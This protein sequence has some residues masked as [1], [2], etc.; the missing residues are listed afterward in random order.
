MLR[1]SALLGRLV[2]DSQIGIWPAAQFVPLRPLHRAIELSLPQR[3]RRY[4]L[5]L[6]VLMFVTCFSYA[7]IAFKS[8][9]IMWRLNRVKGASVIANAM[10][11]DFMYIFYGELNRAKESMCQ[12]YKRR[13][14]VKKSKRTSPTRRYA[15]A[16]GIGRPAFGP[17]AITGSRVPM[18]GSQTLYRFTL[19]IGATLP[20][21]LF[22]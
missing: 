6:L 17:D 9:K 3:Y 19:L 1:C 13:H 8:K 18:L 10:D 2:P 7:P 21:C 16:R 11:S 20:R 22:L 4:I 15:G 5:L 12:Q 14:I